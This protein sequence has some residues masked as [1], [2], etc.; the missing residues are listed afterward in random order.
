MPEFSSHRWWSFWGRVKCPNF[1]VTDGGV[2]GG[3][4]NAIEVNLRLVVIS[5]PID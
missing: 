1:P 5:V 2:F 3:G 4:S